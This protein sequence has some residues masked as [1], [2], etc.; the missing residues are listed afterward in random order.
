MRLRRSFA[1][2]ASMSLVVGLAVAF[3]WPRTANAQAPNYCNYHA[4]IDVEPSG[5]YCG[6]SKTFY[7]KIVHSCSDGDSSYNLCPSGV[8]T[9]IYL[10]L[11]YR[12]DPTT[13]TWWLESGNCTPHQLS[14]S[15]GGGYTECV[16]ISPSGINDGAQWWVGFGIFAGYQAACSSCTSSG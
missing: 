3:P 7:A 11:L 12:L 15:C 14:F 16:G 6:N 9:Q 13:L 10:W 5:S 1:A 8:Q 4:T 2:L